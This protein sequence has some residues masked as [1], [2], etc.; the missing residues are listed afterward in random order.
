MRIACIIVHHLAVQVALAASPVLQGRP[1]VIG[2][3]PFELKPVYDASVEAIACGVSIGMPLREAYALC[4]AA[5]F[6]PADESRYRQVFERVADVLERFSPIVDVEKVGC[7]YIDIGCVRD[8]VSLCH[9]ILRGIYVETGLSACLGVSG[10]KFFSQVAAFTGKPGTPV[11]VGPN[12]ESEFIAPFS[13]DFLPC[14]EKSKGL[15]RL[16]GIRFIGELTL[17]S[18]EALIA[19]FGSDGALMHHLACGIDRSPLVPR[20][21][22]ETVWEDISLDSPV[23]TTTEILQACEALLQRLLAK[24]NE[25]GK[26]CR[27]VV[28]RLGFASAPPQ[29]RR[30]PLKE[31]TNSITVVLL[32]IKA[33]LETVKFPSEV[34]EIGITLS[35]T[36]EQGK[37]LSLW[38]DKKAGEGLLKAAEELKLK[39]GYQPIKKAREVSPP[40]ILPER[41][42]IL[43]DVLE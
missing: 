43:T 27:E 25:Q 34:V 11:I 22:P 28:V 33:W 8:E 4:P 21:K 15:L 35:L 9:Q 26:L 30:L 5:E 14:S 16:L 31:P 10:G 2:G 37:R 42:F 3:L 24:I 40:P 41:R 12:Q 13:I 18:K 20:Q 6:M 19:Q 7:A 17:F 23:M 39:F 36:K 38:R 1:L 32:R 29:E